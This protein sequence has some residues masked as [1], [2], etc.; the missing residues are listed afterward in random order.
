MASS[1]EVIVAA[2]GS[3][4]TCYLLEQALAGPTKRVL[5][6]TYTNENLREINMRLWNAH[7]G[8]PANV[9][10]MTWFEFLLR[11]CVK[12]YQTFK[13]GIAQIRSVNF[14]SENP[15][16]TARSDFDRYYLD[17]AS[18]I[19]SD[20]V[21]DLACVLNSASGSKVIERLEA[22]YDK[23]LV[24]EM[25]DLAGWDLE[26][27]RLL[28]ESSIQI[29]MVGDMR[30]AVYLTNRSNKNSQFRRAGLVN[31]IDARVSAGECRKIEQNQ[32]HRCVQPICDF[33]DSLYP[34]LPTTKSNNSV[35]TGHDGVFLVHESDADSYRR[36]FK[37][38]ELRWDK[39]TTKAGPGAKNFGQVK[40]LSFDRVLVFP[41][42]PI[43]DFLEDGTF[44]PEV[45][46]AK[47]YVAV[48]R[49]RQSVGI[50]VAKKTTQSGLSYW[51]PTS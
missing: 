41:T 50:V 30:Q 5:I 19:Y 7:G 6:V 35:S 31:W 8:Y 39:R 46:A 32:S 38:Q 25:Q 20:A 44:L 51:T 11:E 4:K 10:T 9:E 43:S 21:S 33:A 26:F 12:P 17:S 29:V 37:P 1:N 13:V 15:P 42:G 16:Y 34:N 24:D 18:N 3:G 40:G 22:I 28:L 27:L 23:I 2:A 45:S 36:Y 48:T 49:A 47:F 14:I